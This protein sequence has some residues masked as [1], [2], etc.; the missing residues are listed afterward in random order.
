MR[1]E[2]PMNRRCRS[3]RL[4]TLLALLMLPACPGPRPQVNAEF[5]KGN[6]FTAEG[7]DSSGTLRRQFDCLQTGRQG[8]CVQRKCTE[9]PGGAAFDC[10]SYASACVKA[11]YHWSGTRESGVCSIV[12]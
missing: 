5:D 9:G 1:Q 11:G 10:E 8:E 6:L 7:T 3:I 2:E 12:L 4:A